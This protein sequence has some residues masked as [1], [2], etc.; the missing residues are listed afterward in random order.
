MERR[1][2]TPDAP[3]K[4]ALTAGMP[5]ANNSTL[6]IPVSPGEDLYLSQPDSRNHRQP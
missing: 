3:G 6:G 4:F 2:G 5:Y 1:T